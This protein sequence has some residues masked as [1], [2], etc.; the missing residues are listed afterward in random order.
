MRVLK[1]Y[2]ENKAQRFE[3]HENRV[4]ENEVLSYSD[5]LRYETIKQLF[6]LCQTY[7]P[8]II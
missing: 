4:N 3:R 5:T 7:K 2:V 6:P 8:T 1:Y